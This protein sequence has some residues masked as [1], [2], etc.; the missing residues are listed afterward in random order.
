MIQE[1]GHLIKR[2]QNTH[3]IEIRKECGYS[4]GVIRTGCRCDSHLCRIVFVQRSQMTCGNWCVFKWSV[5]IELRV[6]LKHCANDICVRLF[7][8]CYIVVFTRWYVLLDLIVRI[9]IGLHLIPNAQELKNE[10]CFQLQQTLRI[11]SYKKYSTEIWGCQL[12]NRKKSSEILIN[13][14]SSHFSFTPILGELFYGSLTTPL[15][16]SKFPKLKYLPFLCQSQALDWLQDIHFRIHDPH[17][18]N[19]SLQ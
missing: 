13:F 9:K 8:M 2:D 5:P 7:A 1:C 17:W 4:I 3:K 12:S 16:P 19:E 15:E 11:S 14:R 6:Q 18:H 10:N